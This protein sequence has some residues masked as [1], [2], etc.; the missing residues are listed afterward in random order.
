[1]EVRR[2]LV[3]QSL[4]DLGQLPQAVGAED[5]PKPLDLDFDSTAWALAAPAGH[6][7]PT[8]RQWL[9]QAPP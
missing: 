6:L 5:R 8:R 1:L 4:F 3:S 2:C 7:L 9:G